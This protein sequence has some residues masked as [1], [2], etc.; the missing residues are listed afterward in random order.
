[1]G[2][3]MSLERGFGVVIGRMLMGKRD[4]FGLMI[5]LGGKNGFG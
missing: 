5:G 2:W 4:W 1:V 3:S